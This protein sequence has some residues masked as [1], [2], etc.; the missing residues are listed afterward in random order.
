MNEKH[1]EVTHVSAL[2]TKIGDDWFD[3]DNNV[4]SY[5]ING[6]CNG[7]YIISNYQNNLGIYVIKEC[8]RSDDDDSVEQMHEG[9][10]EHMHVN[11]YVNDCVPDQDVVFWDE[12]YKE[13]R[14]VNRS[15]N[16]NKI[17]M[18]CDSYKIERTKRKTRWQQQILYNDRKNEIK[19][20][21]TKLASEQEDEDECD[22]E[23][24][25]KE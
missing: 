8:I 2:C 9:G 22:Y 7:S 10:D 16:K 17:L 23:H 20:T 25:I 12:Y 19:D 13:Y 1:L 15:F 11:E 6:S 5:G 3:I 24:N 21:R 14:L 4:H 18:S